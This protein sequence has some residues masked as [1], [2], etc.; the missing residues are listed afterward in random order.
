MTHTTY[1]TE[2]DWERIAAPSSAIEDYLEVPTTGS[3]VSGRY[4]NVPNGIVDDIIYHP[5]QPEPLVLVRDNEGLTRAHLLEEI[6]SEGPSTLLQIVDDTDVATIEAASVEPIEAVEVHGA[7]E[8][9][10]L[11]APTAPVTT[12]TDDLLAKINA[13]FAKTLEQ[14]LV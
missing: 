4:A 14:F 7:H 11:D 2:Q 5:G 1:T 9:L 12:S 10:D 13:D 8:V 6:I 3:L